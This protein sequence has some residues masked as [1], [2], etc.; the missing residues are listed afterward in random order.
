LRRRRRP[1]NQFIM[2]FGSM[3]DSVVPQ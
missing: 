3:V 1:V 2:I